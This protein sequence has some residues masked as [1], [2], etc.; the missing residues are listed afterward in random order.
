MSSMHC[1]L[2]QRSDH[3]SGMMT[4]YA[5]KERALQNELDNKNT[6][7]DNLMQKVELDDSKYSAQQI[8]L[9]TLSVKQETIIMTKVK[10]EGL[11]E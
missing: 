8:K 2:V 5:D 10:D 4:N 1:Q 11:A 7:V 9:K 6:N 3:L